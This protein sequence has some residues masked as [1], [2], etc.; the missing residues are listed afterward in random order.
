MIGIFHMSKQPV[1]AKKLRR[2]S[3]SKKVDRELKTL[4]R[5]RESPAGDWQI[6]DIQ[7][8]STYLGLTCTSPTRGTH[9]KVSSSFLEGILTVPA[10][11]PIKVPY[12]KKFIA[13]IDA[14]IAKTA[15]GDHDE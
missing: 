11:R 3:S 13:L 6:G 5:M 15:K 10:H 9:Y 1:K 7:K 14:H 8:I 4:E 12:I 2:Q